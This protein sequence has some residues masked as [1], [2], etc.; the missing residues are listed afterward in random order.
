IRLAGRNVLRA[1]TLCLQSPWRGQSFCRPLWFRCGCG[2]GC[3]HGRDRRCR[4]RLYLRRNRPQ[5]SLELAVAEQSLDRDSFFRYGVR[6]RTGD[7]DPRCARH[8]LRR[9]LH[10]W[11]W[12]D[13]VGQRRVSRYWL[14]DLR[15]NDAQQLR[16]GWGAG[17]TLEKFPQNRDVADSRNLVQRLG[18]PLIQ[19]SRDGEALSAFEFY[20]GVDLP[21]IQPW[22]VY[23]PKRDTTGE[24]EKAY[25]RGH[26]KTNGPS[27]S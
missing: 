7:L 15:R 6:C 3:G 11:L 24:I 1:I 23:P 18:E 20:F 14:H 12:P 4:N 26:V 9:V 27:G 22:N 8:V 19:K 25:F 16:V 21:G 17:F 5:T 2:C 10:K 13:Q